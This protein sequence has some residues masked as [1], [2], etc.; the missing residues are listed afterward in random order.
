MPTLP[1]T[2][3]PRVKA[4]RRLTL[5]IYLRNPVALAWTA[6]YRGPMRHLPPDNVAKGLIASGGQRMLAL[7]DMKR[8][9]RSGQRALFGQ[10]R[11]ATGVR[12]AC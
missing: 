4:R 6:T 3:R 1:E 8:G 12:G 11:P 9:A 7:V 5:A 2:A 10:R